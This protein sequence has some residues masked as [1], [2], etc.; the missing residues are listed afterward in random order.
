MKKSLTE[1]LSQSFLKMVVLPLVILSVSLILVFI[2]V[3]S[4]VLTEI[5][6]MELHKNQVVLE[7]ILSSRVSVLE[8]EFEDLTN[9]DDKILED[10]FKVKLPFEAKLTLK[11]TTEKLLEIN[12]V[13]ISSI[14]YLQFSKKLKY[15]D[16]YLVLSV[17]KIK[18]LE[19]INSVSNM[20]FNI[21]LGLGFLFFFIIFFIYKMSSREFKK[22]SNHMIKPIIALARIDL[23]SDEFTS[24]FP[25]LNTGLIEI[26]KLNDS[27]IGMVKKL[28]NFN[29]E[30]E[31]RV[32]E[33][34]HG[35]QEKTKNINNLFNAMMEA[36][37]IC[38]QKNNIV[39]VNK[40]GLKLFGT[41]K[42]E[43][44]VGHNIF[45]F[46]PKSEHHK[47]MQSF[48][49]DS[50]TPYEVILYK[51]NK[52]TTY[53]AL[54]KGG[55]TTINN[56]LHRIITII[57]ITDIKE[58]DK[59]LLQQSK[60]AQMGEM[61]S[62]I[63]HQ[64]RQ[65][66]NAISAS[67]INLSLLS[68]MN[69]LED[70]KV[71]ESSQFIQDQAHKMSQTIDTFMNFVRPS[72]ES[73]FFHLKHTIDAV[74][75]IM[76]TQLANHNIEVK[77]TITDENISMLGHEDLLEQVIINLLSNARDAFEDLELALKFINITLDMENDE[78][79]LIIIEDNAGGI[80]REIQDKIFNPYF[81]TK[82][83]GKGT[84]IGLYM[85]LDIMKKSFGGDLKF[86]AT[87]GGSCFSIVC[88]K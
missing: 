1:K 68:S 22:I 11:K 16:I 12:E 47:A 70:E 65:P 25:K 73:K 29:K 61:I 28:Q 15:K 87:K 46:I 39:Q 75:Q 71:Q 34:T 63:A 49:N 62:M 2:S 58:K 18:I 3:R 36:L 54:I 44:I 31:K 72:Q 85:S 86:D 21:I 52:T 8:H 66:L 33:S 19:T 64:W 81:T 79:P 83:Q 50:I 57:D 4:Y 35:L 84:G 60:E 26:D 78:T 24:S 82:E 76:G 80:P 20:S 43:D 17:E 37:L 6:S 27:F 7:T 38:D 23:N 67:G 30:L 42:K 77:I 48:S 88:G 5:Y 51:H 41:T 10:F 74:M 53:S 59:Q 56:A 13:N 40:V 9:F 32:Q 69:M 45:E 14:I 55:M